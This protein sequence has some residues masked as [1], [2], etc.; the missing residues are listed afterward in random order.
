MSF[1]KALE[2]LKS[3]K[4][5]KRIGWNGKEQ[6][7]CLGNRIEWREGDVSYRE[8]DMNVIVFHGTHSTQVGWLASQADM[9]KDDWEV[10]E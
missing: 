2:S 3:G 4:R 5:L 9:L 7:I 1:S 8:D 10:I 6:Y